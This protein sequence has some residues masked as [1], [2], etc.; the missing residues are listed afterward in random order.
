MP[1]EK[2]AEQINRQAKSR[3][4]TAE[5]KQGA[6]RTGSVQK[7]LNALQTEGHCTLQSKKEEEPENM[8]WERSA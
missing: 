8:R 6:L 5:Q 3:T 7:N 1:P 4:P 2:K